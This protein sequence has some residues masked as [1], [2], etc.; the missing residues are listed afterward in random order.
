MLLLMIEML[1]H[2]GLQGLALSRL[3]YG[4]ISLLVYLPLV[5]QLSSNRSRSRSSVLAIPI[6]AREASKP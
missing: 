2:R 6:E 5:Q 4:S 3:F 1:R